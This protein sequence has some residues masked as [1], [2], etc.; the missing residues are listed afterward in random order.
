[1]FTVVCCYQAPDLYERV[2]AAG[3][4]GQEPHQLLLHCNTEAENLPL[5]EVYN[6]LAAQAEGEALLFVHQDVSLL[7]GALH[8]IGEKLRALEARGAR[9]GLVG[10]AGAGPDR[11]LHNGTCDPEH[12]RGFHVEVQTLDEA[13]FACRL[14]DFRQAGGFT[15]APELAWHC[16]AA[17]LALKMNREGRHNY[18]VQVLAQ[19]VG[20]HHASVEKL[21]DLHDAQRWIAMNWRQPVGTSG[22]LLKLIPGGSSPTLLG[23][24]IMHRG[25]Q[26]HSTVLE[27]LRRLTEVGD[28]GPGGT[29]PAAP[30]TSAWRGGP[31]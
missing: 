26:A 30:G 17:D 3:L 18:V 29:C 1:V 16:Y 11:W 4:A 6:R 15:E 13:L 10:L 19:H 21:S 24:A 23:E 20:P 22:G 28:S 31:R 27:N 7:P 5:P 9:P 2:F 8:R 25:R 12:Y 14:A